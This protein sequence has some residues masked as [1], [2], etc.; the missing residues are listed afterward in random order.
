M[1]AARG[2]RQRLLHALPRRESEFVVS[3][4][5]EETVGGAL[6]LVAAFVAV[7]WA[8]SPAADSYQA[9]R[10]VVVGPAALHLDLTLQEWTADG[11]LAVFFFVAGLELKRELVVGQLRKPSEAVLPMVAAVSGMVVPAGV[12][13]AV[14]ATEP[15]VLEGWAVPIATDI[16]FALAV[17]AVIGSGLPTALRAFL[18]T[19]AV[20]DDLGAILVI[21]VGFTDDL[22]VAALGAAAAV[23]AGYTYLQHRRV[24][25]WLVLVPTAVLL[26]VLVHESGVHAT[27]AGVALGLA[28]RVRPDPGE[29]R[30]PAEHLEHLVR[31]VSAGIAV[32]LFALFSAGVPVTP[33]SLGDAVADTAA[34][35][36]VAALVVG[37]FVGVLGGTY[38]TARL[39]RA[40]L[41]PEL[42]WA[43]VAAVA[44]LSGIGFTVS[45]LIADLAFSGS[46]RL[47]HVKTA[48]LAG[49]LLSALLASA[50]L[51]Q[52]NRRHRRRRDAIIGHTERDDD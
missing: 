43:D 18:L 8:S 6:L 29:D 26:W 20:V 13:A 33:G 47:D 19:L 40:E 37:K 45:L 35:A 7:V 2:A 36:V 4:L 14:A 27:I 23:L 16:A 17:L 24:H 50:V 44:F 11:L 9:M 52:R 22:D 25:A 3:A 46:D 48:V 12:Y 30:S 1:T 31:P 21:A 42:R 5:R 28:T 39:T 49:S 51:R 32:P 41:S 34:V 38:L 15:E 10:D